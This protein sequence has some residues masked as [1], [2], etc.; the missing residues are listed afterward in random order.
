LAT[1]LAVAAHDVLKATVMIED[2]I[3]RGL[4][5][6]TGK[7]RCTGCLADVPAAEYFACDF[8]CRECAG[9]SGLYPLASTPGEP[10]PASARAG[11]ESGGST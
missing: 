4:P 8:M 5:E 10:S 7:H 1:Y 11:G 2:E 3:P 6:L 9:K